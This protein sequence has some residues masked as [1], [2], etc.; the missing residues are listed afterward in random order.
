MPDYLRRIEV[1]EDRIDPPSQP[2]GFLLVVCNRAETHEEALARHWAEQGTEP[3]PAE[4]T[5][6]VNTSHNA[7]PEH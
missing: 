6:V 3:R 1:L 2:L 5:L 7:H 4:Y